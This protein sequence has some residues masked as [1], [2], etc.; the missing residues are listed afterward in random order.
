MIWLLKQGSPL[1]KYRTKRNL[2]IVCDWL[3]EFHTITKS[4]EVILDPDSLKKYFTP[5]YNAI[6]SYV[7]EDN[8][9]T[10]MSKLDN[11]KSSVQ[12]KTIPMVLM[13]GDFGPPNIYLDGNTVIVLDWE[14]A[15]EQGEPLYDLYYFLSHYMFLV[16][17]DLKVYPIVDF[18]TI[19]NFTEK[20]FFQGSSDIHNL[21]SQLVKKYCESLKIDIAIAKMLFLWQEIDKN[22]NRNILSLFLIKKINS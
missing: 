1:W 20:I 11:L 14:W 13:H 9:K 22:K 19:S 15:K 10:I 16:Y 21:I 3:I 7:K 12:G 2:S 8:E 5:L 4:G 6:E 18:Q 17:S